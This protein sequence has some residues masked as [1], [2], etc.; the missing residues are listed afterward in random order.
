MR[1]EGV[2]HVETAV[3]GAEA[4]A[5]IRAAEFELVMTDLRMPGGDGVQLIQRIAELEN[6]PQLALISASPKQLVGTV[7]LLAKLLSIKVVGQL[8]KPVQAVD[9][10]L[11]IKTPRSWPTSENRS[12]P[13]SRMTAICSAAMVH[14]ANGLGDCPAYGLW[15]SPRPRMSVSTTVKPSVRLGAISCQQR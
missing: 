11:L 3:N 8:C 12:K 13:N 2:T 15:L 1:R 14:F 5:R 9:I 10:R 6:P 7:H 4:L